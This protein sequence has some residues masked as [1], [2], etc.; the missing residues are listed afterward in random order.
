[1]SSGLKVMSVLNLRPR[2]IGSFEEYTITLSRAL[3]ERGGQSILVF[4][5]TPPDAL[6]PQYLEAGVILEAKP[7]GP[8]GRESA[9]SLRALV[10][11]Y[12]PDVVHL[13]FVNLLS[14]DVVGAALHRGVR[15]VYSEH[16]SDIAKAR[17]ALR[18]HGLRAGKRV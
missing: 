13:H 1:M 15:V 2:K 3:G 12:Q 8:F 9:A 16:A 7:F 4:K 18:W 5:E 11:R 17:T 10:C 6:R 14:L